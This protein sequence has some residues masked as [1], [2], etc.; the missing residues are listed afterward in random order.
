M[1]FGW[2]IFVP[3]FPQPGLDFESAILDLNFSDLHGASGDMIPMIRRTCDLRAAKSIKN[4]Q[5]N[6]NNFTLRHVARNKIV[7]FT[8]RFSF[9][10]DMAF[11]ML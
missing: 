4:T 10:L 5:L 6:F 11:F 2:V 7:I 1:L 3:L 9:I 8:P